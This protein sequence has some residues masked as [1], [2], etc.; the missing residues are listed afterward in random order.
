MHALNI[1]TSTCGSHAKGQLR[2]H[3]FSQATFYQSIR[4]PAFCFNIKIKLV[5]ILSSEKQE[6]NK[7]SI[8]EKSEILRDK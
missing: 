4:F 5:D 7:I 8:F 2:T 6:R 3:L 1:I